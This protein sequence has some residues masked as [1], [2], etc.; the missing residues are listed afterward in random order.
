MW[1]VSTRS[2]IH[3][4]KVRTTWEDSVFKSG[5]RSDSQ[6]D[7]YQPSEQRILLDGT[8]RG[9]ETRMAEER[10]ILYLLLVLP[11]RRLAVSMVVR[12]GVQWTVVRRWEKGIA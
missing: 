10:T 4:C 5:I 12:G 7:E 2:L 1:Y 3:L 9:N 6:P 11:V 8:R